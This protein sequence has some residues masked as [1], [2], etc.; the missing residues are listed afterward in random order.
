M[1]KPNVVSI[2]ITEINL[3]ENVDFIVIGSGTPDDNEIETLTGYYENVG[4]ITSQGSQ[5]W[6]RLMTDESVNG[7]GFMLSWQQIE[8]DGGEKG[9]AILFPNQSLLIR[10]QR[11]QYK[12][13]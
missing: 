6:V 10:R 13:G 5:M 1:T 9:V 12:C 2:T 8:D 4:P 11:N 7:P 3:E